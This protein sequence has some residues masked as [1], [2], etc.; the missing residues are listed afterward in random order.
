M[1]LSYEEEIELRRDTVLE[2]ASKGWTQ[3]QIAQKLGYSQ[4]QISKD[5]AVIRSKAREQLA[6]HYQELPIR[7]RIVISN[8]EQIRKEAWQTVANTQDAR[9]R[10]VLF[11]TLISVNREIL[12]VIAAGDLIEQEVANAE[13]IAKEAK[14]DLE[15][16]K[17]RLAEQ[18]DGSGSKTEGGTD[19]QIGGFDPENSI[20]TSTTSSLSTS[21]T[22]PQ[23]VLDSRGAIVLAKAED[24]STREAEEE[25]EEEEVDDHDADAYAPPS[26]STTADTIPSDAMHMITYEVVADD[27]TVDSTVVKE[28]KREVVVDDSSSSSYDVDDDGDNEEQ[29]GDH[30]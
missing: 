26:S 21:D 18:A 25:E 3:H 17:E 20:P 15:K 23:E 12:D 28:E 1:P 13:I 30:S 8:L 10:S 22:A 2:L 4:A 19:P 29:V 14:D 11:N 24:S 27:A 9:S 16:A 7:Y 6:S 5:L